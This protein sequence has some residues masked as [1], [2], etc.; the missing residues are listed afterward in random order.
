MIPTA[1]TISATSPNICTID[2][3]SIAGNVLISFVGSLFVVFLL[4][5]LVCLSSWH[6]KCEFE[7]AQTAQVMGEETRRTS[8]S[9]ELWFVRGTTPVNWWTNRMV[10]ANQQTGKLLTDLSWKAWWR[11]RTLR[12]PGPPPEYTFLDEPLPEGNGSELMLTG[13]KRERKRKRKRQIRRLINIIIKNLRPLNARLWRHRAGEAHGRGE[14]VRP[15]NA[16]LWRH[17]AK[18]AWKLFCSCVCNPLPKVTGGQDQVIIAFR[19]ECDA[20]ENYF[21]RFTDKMGKPL[22]HRRKFPANRNIYIH[23][24]LRRPKFLKSVLRQRLA[25]WY[26]LQL[27]DGGIRVLWQQQQ[28][29]L[30]TELTDYRYRIPLV[31]VDQDVDVSLSI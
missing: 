21:I 18:R 3:W 30:E 12:I 4:V 19:V 28:K 31:Y 25:C 9:L 6:T 27:T 5:I 22:K 2:V 14:L 10:I 16:R 23:Y 1:S 20:H 15:L 17:R 26:V 13:G 29:V 8:G 11:Q 7:R 24:T